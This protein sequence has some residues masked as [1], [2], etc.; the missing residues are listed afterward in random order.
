MLPPE[1]Y[2]MVKSF[3]TTQDLYR[4]DLTCYAICASTISRKEQHLRGC[5][6][7]NEKG[8]KNILAITKWRNCDHVVCWKLRLKYLKFRDIFKTHNSPLAHVV[9]H[10]KLHIVRFVCESYDVSV[11]HCSIVL[12]NFLKICRNLETAK[13]LCK[14]YNLHS[15]IYQQPHHHFVAEFVKSSGRTDR[16]DRI[17]ILNYFLEYFET[18]LSVTI[19]SLLDAAIRNNRLAEVICFY[20]KLNLDNSQDARYFYFCLRNN[21]FEILNYLCKRQKDIHLVN[22]SDLLPMPWYSNQDD[23]SIPYDFYCAC[24]S[25]HLESVQIVCE[26]FDVPI[27]PI[28]QNKHYNLLEKLIYHNRLEML[29]YL[30][31]KYDI[32]PREFIWNQSLKWIVENF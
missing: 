22:A 16:P 2:V 17:K 31:V 23:R 3:C 12:F 15:K 30:V 24:C 1:M 20:E 26:N 8:R 21:Y 25:G 29:Q 18:D 6:L 11:A 4:M 32:N 19:R 28:F 13:Y 10:N 9:K 5:H 14:K 7:W 27:L